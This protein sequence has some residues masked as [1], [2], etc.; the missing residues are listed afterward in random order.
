VNTKTNTRKI[1][2]L[3]DK[4]NSRVSAVLGLSFRDQVLLVAGF[5]TGFFGLQAAFTYV[6]WGFI[7]LTV[8]KFT[9]LSLKESLSPD[10]SGLEGKTLP[11][12]TEEEEREQFFALQEDAPIYDPE[13]DGSRA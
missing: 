11:G 5:I 12:R 7:V 2:E 13:S 6:V 1:C 10:T 4:V 9:L 3:A 8:L